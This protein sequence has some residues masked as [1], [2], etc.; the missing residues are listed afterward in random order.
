MLMLVAF[1]H[2]L[3]V[4]KHIDAAK[5]M[6]RRK[7][8]ENRTAHQALKRNRYAVIPNIYWQRTY[9]LSI[10]N[11]QRSLS[12]VHSNHD[13]RRDSVYLLLKEQCIL[14]NAVDWQDNLSKRPVLLCL[15]GWQTNFQ[16]ASRDLFVSSQLDSPKIYSIVAIGPEANGK[17]PE[18]T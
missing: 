9:P 1:I 18:Q 3:E 7:V 16:N 5:V 2:R 4:G 17:V 14:I 13:L 8:M 11:T 12:A 15:Q 6:G 10:S